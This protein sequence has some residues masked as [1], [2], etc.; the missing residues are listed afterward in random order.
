[1]GC[2]EIEVRMG[3]GP[4]V[5]GEG[6]GLGDPRQDLP[7]SAGWCLGEGT[8]Q[9]GSHADGALRDGAGD[10]RQAGRPGASSAGG[11]GPQ[12]VCTHGWTCSW[13]CFKG[14]DGAA[15]HG[16]TFS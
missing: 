3:R 2:W 13:V 15:L 7:W 12:W 8:G 16:K 6:A 11:Q 9:S 5:G 4:G 1:M 14:L 10:G